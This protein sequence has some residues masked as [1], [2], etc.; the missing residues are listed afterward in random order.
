MAI[1][2]T[3]EGLEGSS[4]VSTR[5]IGLGTLPTSLIFLVSNFHSFVTHKSRFNKLYILWRTQIQNVLRASGYLG[6]VDGY[7]RCPVSEIEDPNR[8]VLK[9]W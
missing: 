7:V 9:T 2:A 1:M 8:T 5:K 6:Y 4:S 3:R